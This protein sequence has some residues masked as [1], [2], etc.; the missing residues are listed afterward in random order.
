MNVLPGI[1]YI[2]PEYMP[3][4]VPAKPKHLKK[5]IEVARKLSEDFGFVRVDLYE[6]RDQ[7]YISELTFFPWGG[8]L[9][10]YTDEAIKLYG[11]K[12]NAAMKA[13]SK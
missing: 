5:M 4:H 6:Y 11:D 2:K 10:G 3:K 12:W 7:P 1:Y 13:K 8:M 9:Y